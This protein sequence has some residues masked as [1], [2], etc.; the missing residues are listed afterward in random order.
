MLCVRTV[1]LA[2][3]RQAIRIAPER[4][5]PP[6][7][8]DDG[9]SCA[10]NMRMARAASKPRKTPTNVSIRSDL[11][12]RAKA[13]KVN[14]SQLLE[15]ALEAELKERERLEW[16]E[17]NAEAIAAYKQ[18]LSLQPEFP[19]AAFNLE[20]VEGLLAQDNKEYDDA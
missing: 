4:I 16:L 5:G 14:L 20:W 18:A 8:V 12:K 7:L 17:A 3:A 11:V 13:L 15:R 19:E 9:H 2:D 1:L 6:R 10:Y